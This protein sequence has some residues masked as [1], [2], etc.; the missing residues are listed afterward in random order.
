MSSVLFL[1]LSDHLAQLSIVHLS[2]KDKD[3]Y[4]ILYFLRLLLCRVCLLLVLGHR[5]YVVSRY[6]HHRLEY[7]LT[8]PTIQSNN[9]LSSLLPPLPHHHYP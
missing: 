7:N 2:L 6:L 4:Y 8:N 3:Q 5:I 9:H 1:L